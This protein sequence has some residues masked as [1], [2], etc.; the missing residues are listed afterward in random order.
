MISFPQRIA[1]LFFLLLLVAA[2]PVPCP[3]DTPTPAGE[4]KPFRVIYVEGG[5]Y[6]YYTDCLHGL[7]TGLEAM[8]VIP[9]LPDRQDA[10]TMWNQASGLKPDKIHF[11]PDGFYSAGWDR[12]LRHRNKEAILTRI[13]DKGDIDLILAMGTWAGVDMA[14]DEHQ[15]PI[16]AL[17]TSDAFSAGII[18]TPTE[19]G[20]P[21]VYAVITPDWLPRQIFFFYKLFKFKRLGL[22]YDDSVEG[23]HEVGLEVLQRLAPVLGFDLVECSDRLD[24]PDLEL[25][26]DR[27]LA[28]HNKLA[29]KVDAMY[30]TASGAL[31]PQ[32]IPTLIA[33]FMARNIPTFAQASPEG[34]REG[35]LLDIAQTV[36]EEEGAFAAA[37]L[38][39]IL[40]GVRPD[41]AQ[42]MFA[43]KIM[44]SLNMDTARAIGWKPP[45]SLLQSLDILYSKGQI[46]RVQ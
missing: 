23:R 30:I 20:R 22:T 21:H 12:E 8:G 27:L 15:V 6:N 16:M 33:P 35:I 45:Y 28:C 24:I 37:A 42:Q 14:T 32:Y 1:S 41:R 4:K 13:R 25:S 38:G 29:N 9:A 39:Q 10:R 36:P 43:G 40:Q 5:D 3:A 11:L 18:K 26:R 7:L 17:S 46:K 34:V 2:R 19:S 31:L 44:I